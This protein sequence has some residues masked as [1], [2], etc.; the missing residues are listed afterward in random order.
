[1][2][3]IFKCPHTL[4]VLKQVSVLQGI[5]E[6]MIDVWQYKPYKYGLINKYICNNHPCHRQVFTWKKGSATWTGASLYGQILILSITYAK[7]YHYQV[8]FQLPNSLNSVKLRYNVPHSD[9]KK[10]WYVIY[11]NAFISMHMGLFL[12]TATHIIHIQ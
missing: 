8:S 10:V 1:M 6:M 12:E 3:R 2:I 7:Q 11:N 9:Q 5:F 4:K